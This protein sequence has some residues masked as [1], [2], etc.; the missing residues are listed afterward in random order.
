MSCDELEALRVGLCN[1]LGIDRPAIREHALAELEGNLDGPIGALINAESLAELER[2][3]DGALV[4]L[5][6]K[7]ANTPS[8]DPEYDYLRGR[9]LALREAE[10]S[11]RRLRA[12]GEAILEGCGETHS[13]LH[14]LFPVEG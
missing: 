14:E 12:D 2:H 1:V 4:D 5:E 13:L 6:A 9:L 8:N 11:M 3:L 10:R 7:L